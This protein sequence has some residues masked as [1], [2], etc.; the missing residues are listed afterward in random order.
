MTTPEKAKEIH[1][2]EQLATAIRQLAYTTAMMWL[3]L[4]KQGVPATPATQLVSAWLAANARPQQ[5]HKEAG[6]P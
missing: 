1:Q 5:P 6:S 2:E 4:I 3:E